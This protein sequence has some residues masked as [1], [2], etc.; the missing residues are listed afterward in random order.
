MSDNNDEQQVP[1]EFIKV[2]RD[3]VGDLKATFPEYDPFIQ[4][5]WKCKEEFALYSLGCVK[6][7]LTFFAN[8]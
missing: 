6:N 5:W 2:I 1:E 8:N 7:W 3:F 4:K